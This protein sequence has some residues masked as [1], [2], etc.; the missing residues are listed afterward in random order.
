MI[1]NTFATLGLMLSLCHGLENEAD[2]AF[3]TSLESELVE[4]T[5]PSK[6]SPIWEKY[7]NSGTVINM[8]VGTK[9]RTS[10]TNGR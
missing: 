10:F 7:P 2:I 3:I 4:M 9:K 1:R 8:A 6:E 5:C